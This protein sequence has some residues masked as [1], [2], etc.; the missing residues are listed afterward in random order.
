MITYTSQAFQQGP[1]QNFPFYN[2]NGEP[3]EAEALVKE[4]K[5]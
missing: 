2:K 3:Y 5:P 4:E 1:N